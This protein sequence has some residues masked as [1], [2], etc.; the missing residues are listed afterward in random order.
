MGVE[1]ADGLPVLRLRARAGA[2]DDLLEDEEAVDEVPPA[3]AVVDRD[4][5]PGAVVVLLEA[6]HLL[7]CRIDH[8]IR[9]A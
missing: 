9:R 3:A 2:R 8:R 6:L 7:L 5:R 4:R 1:E